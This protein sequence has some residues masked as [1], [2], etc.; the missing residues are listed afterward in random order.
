MNIK[1]LWNKIVKTKNDK[2]NLENEEL[3]SLTMVNFSLLL[4]AK[5]IISDF[6]EYEELMTNQLLVQGYQTFD[7]NLETES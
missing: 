3:I 4:H 5:K 1:L 6:F 7:Q 2:H